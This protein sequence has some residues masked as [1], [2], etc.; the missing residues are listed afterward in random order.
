[1]LITGCASTSILER[2]DGTHLMVATSFHEGSALSAA[3]EEATTFCAKQGMRFV[4]VSHKSEYQGADKDMKSIMGMVSSIH[5]SYHRPRHYA[6]AYY[7]GSH[8]D[9]HRVELIFKCL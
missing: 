7:D 9:D 6:P 3:N 2:A 1:M 8:P 5:Q 4:L